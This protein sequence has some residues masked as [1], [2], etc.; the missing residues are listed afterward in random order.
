MKLNELKDK[1]TH[2]AHFINTLKTND[3]PTSIM[4]HLNNKPQELH[5]PSK[6]CFLKLP[7]FSEIIIKE[8]HRAIY[9]KGLDIQLAHS[10]PTLRQYLTKKN[11]NAVTTCTLANC[12][13]KDPNICQKKLTLFIV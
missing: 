6:T 11:N 5:T 2:T 9:K 7:H 1:I 10:G 13:R 12:P 4:R 3:Y 8:I